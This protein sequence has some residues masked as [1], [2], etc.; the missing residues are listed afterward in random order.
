MKLPLRWLVLLPC[1]VLLFVPVLGYY[2]LESWQGELERSRGAQLQQSADT[3]A[4]LLANNRDVM[5]RLSVA[6][7]LPDTLHAVR[8][9]RELVLDGRQNDWPGHVPKSFGVDQLVEIDFPYVANSLQFELSVG[10]DADYLYL[11]YA[12]RD[13]CEKCPFGQKYT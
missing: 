1:G 2:W 4:A 5:A 6:D 8:V 7:P 13:T 11:F 12:V 9:E 3:I 10:A